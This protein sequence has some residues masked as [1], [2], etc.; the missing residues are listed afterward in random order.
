MDKRDVEKRMGQPNVVRIGKKVSDDTVYE[1]HEYKLYDDFSV[2]ALDFSLIIPAQLV[3]GT[4]T[5]W[6]HY[7]NSKL[8]FWGEEGNWRGAPKWFSSYYANPSA[9]Q[10]GTESKAPNAANPN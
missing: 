9:G 2:T 7:I 4:E 3:L 5:Y 8:V 10:T 6:L 1:L